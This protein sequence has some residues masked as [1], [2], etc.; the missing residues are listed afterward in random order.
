M[1][2]K[3][4]GMLA[5]FPRGFSSLETWFSHGSP[6]I[7]I[8]FR[9]NKPP[10]RHSSATIR[11]HPQCTSL[12]QRVNRRSRSERQDAAPRRVRPVGW[13]NCL[14]IILR[15]TILVRGFRVW[16]VTRVL[17]NSC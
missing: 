2:V 12:C 5:R 10:R 6:G 17:S 7:P 14:M 4:S 15:T 1:Q 3:I 9:T 16:N 8:S 13:I 11:S